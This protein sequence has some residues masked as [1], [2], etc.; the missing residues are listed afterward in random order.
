MQ[1]Q[2]LIL[3][4]LT[5]KA[6]CGTAWVKEARDGPVQ[7]L[8]V[9]G[10]VTGV[11]PRDSEY[12]RSWRLAGQFFAETPDGRR[13]TSSIA[14]LPQSIESMI[15]A[16]AEDGRI[17]EFS[18][19][20]GAEPSESPI[21]YQYT[22]ASLVPVRPP[23]SMQRLVLAFNE[24]QEADQAAEDDAV[25]DED[26]VEDSEPAKPAKAGRSRRRS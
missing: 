22:I 24:S 18:M 7:L 15:V 25:E 20:I 16:A 23:E 1:A 10:M 19:S 21:G 2:P 17:V 5:L 12:G 3:K 26:E 6:C 14:Y 8:K 11:E 4:K 9:A 13:F